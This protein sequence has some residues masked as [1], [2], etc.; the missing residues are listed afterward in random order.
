MNRTLFKAGLVAAALTLA[1]MAA[2][3]NE[4][5][6][7]SILDAQRSGASTT[8]IVDLV[9]RP[10]NT[11]D[12]TAADIIQ[13]RDAGVSERVISAIWDKL[14]A[15]PAANVPDQPDDPRLVD[16]VRLIKSG[17]STSLIDEQVAQSPQ[18]Y[19]LT[20]NDLIYLKGN[21]ARESTIAVLMATGG[22]PGAPAV[23]PAELVF[24][25]LVMANK[26]FWR[27]DAIGRLVLRGNTLSWENTKHPR[28]NFSF[29]TTGL[30]KVWL[31]CEARSSG[32][33]CHQINFKIVK[34]ER[35]KFQDRDR[36][37]GANA[38]VLELME[39]LRTYQPRITY[40]TPNVDD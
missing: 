19:R 10:D 26:G 6:V 30:E 3:A 37:T 5:T 27:R 28:K 31:T 13:L 22:Q 14:P 29:E 33:F 9:N 34:G 7:D 1:A 8:N 21:G 25:N 39:G 15:P 11:V 20:V 38:A 17:M 32:A 23:A 35:Y 40:A 16:F 2:S 12:M 18:A 24:D 4:L 36:E